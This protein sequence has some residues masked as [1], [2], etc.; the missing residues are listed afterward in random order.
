V[1]FARHRSGIVACRRATRRT[2][3]IDVT[4][5]PDQIFRTR[6]AAPLYRLI[7]PCPADTLGPWAT[8]FPDYDEVVGYSSLGHFFLRAAAT[9]EYIVLYPLRG[10]AKSYGEYDSVEAFEAE[11]LQDEGFTAYVLRPDH[12][13]EIAARLGA[14]GDDEVYIPAPFPFLGGSDAPETYQKGDVW[15]FAAL[16]AQMGG[17]GE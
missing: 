6:Q 15:V 11:V 3:S 14:L 8:A 13:D 9:Q 10:A 5:M 16:V 4:D 2:L 17:L 1:H 12:V 7:A